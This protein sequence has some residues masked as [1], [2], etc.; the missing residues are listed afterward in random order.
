MKIPQSEL[1]KAFTRRPSEFLES[2]KQWRGMRLLHITDSCSYIDMEAIVQVRFSRQVEPYICMIEKDFTTQVLLSSVRIADTNASNFYQ[3]LRKNISSGKSRY[4][5]IEVDKLRED[6]GIEKHETY[7]NYKFLKSQ[8]IDRAIKKIL[9]ITEFKKIE[10]K[11][12]ERKGRKAH[13]IMI[14][15]EY[16]NC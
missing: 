8:F 6:L 1:L 14:S 2:E 7:K 13:K 16:E 9:N 10:V 4:F 12:L 5:E 11:I 3:Y 15:Y